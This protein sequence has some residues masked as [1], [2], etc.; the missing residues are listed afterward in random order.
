MRPQAGR[1]RPLTSVRGSDPSAVQP[2]LDP[3]QRIRPRRDHMAFA[4]SAAQLPHRAERQGPGLHILERAQQA[5][6]RQRHAR[7]R[8]EP[9]AVQVHQGRRDPGHVGRQRLLRPC[10]RHVRPR[11]AG[12]E[13][14][15]HLVPELDEDGLQGRLSRG[16]PRHGLLHFRVR[17][18]LPGN[19]AL[20]ELHHRPVRNRGEDIARRSG[21]RER[22]QGDR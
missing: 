18:Q 19:P 10:R 8:A 12:D 22:G 2:V 9:H 16:P 14:D 1:C 3:P 17:P 6:G 7:L 13:A 5:D 21:F 4:D 20:A 15:I 11:D